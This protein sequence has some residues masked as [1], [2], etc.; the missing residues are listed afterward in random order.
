MNVI[1]MLACLRLPVCS[2]ICVITCGHINSLRSCYCGLVKY[3]EQ[4]KLLNMGRML[5]I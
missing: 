5:T 4:N 3:F 2:F 1:T